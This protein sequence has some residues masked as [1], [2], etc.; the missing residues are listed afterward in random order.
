MEHQDDHKSV[1]EYPAGLGVQEH[2][3]FASHLG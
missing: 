1:S 2:F 3:D